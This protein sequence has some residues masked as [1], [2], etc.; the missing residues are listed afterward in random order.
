MSGDEQ[1]TVVS[2]LLARGGLC[3]GIA[4]T[5]RAHGAR[6]SSFRFHALN[7]SLCRATTRILTALEETRDME[8]VSVV[9]RLSM[10]PS[11]STRPPEWALQVVQTP[12]IIDEIGRRIEP[13][14]SAMREAGL[15]C[16]ALALCRGLDSGLSLAHRLPREDAASLESKLYL[17][18]ALNRPGEPRRMKDRIVEILDEIAREKVS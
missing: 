6:S 2:A 11:P 16:L 10:G 1:S 9:T 7:E 3:F 15:S 12:H 17:Y 14:T 13:G 5:A 4:A 18:G 8:A